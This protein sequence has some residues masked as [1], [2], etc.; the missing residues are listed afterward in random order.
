MRD[1]KLETI[2]LLKEFQKYVEIDPL[3]ELDFCTCLNMFNGSSYE[4][5]VEQAKQDM[6]EIRRSGEL[7][8][9]NKEHSPSNQR[10]MDN[11]KKVRQDIRLQSP[12]IKNRK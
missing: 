5:A 8:T 11:L 3:F 10:K 12:V 2:E 1:A 7:S 4:D 9:G 6:R